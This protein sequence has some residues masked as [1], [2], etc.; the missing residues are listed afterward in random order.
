MFVCRIITVYSVQIGCMYVSIINIKNKKG[1][2][3]ILKLRMPL[4]KMEINT[5]NR[6]LKYAFSLLFNWRKNDRVM[7]IKESS[8]T[9]L[10][11]NVWK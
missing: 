11:P 7:E 6:N 4:K 8:H 5:R 1:C 3:I 9:F 2:K 10:R